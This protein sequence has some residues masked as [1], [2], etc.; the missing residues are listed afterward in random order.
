MLFLHIPHIR[1][2]YDKFSDKEQWIILIAIDFYSLNGK[3]YVFIYIF[4]SIYQIIR[5]DL[6]DFMLPKTILLHTRHSR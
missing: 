3:S 5:L 6:G 1:S 4:Y 2:K